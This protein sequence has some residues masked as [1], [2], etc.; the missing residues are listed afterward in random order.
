MTFVSGSVAW[1]LGHPYCHSIFVIGSRSQDRGI[2][3]TKTLTRV[4]RQ[5]SRRH[6][7]GFCL[8][9]ISTLTLFVANSAIAQVKLAGQSSAVSI[10]PAN[11]NPE[12]GK[13]T[14]FIALINTGDVV[15]MRRSRQPP[16]IQ[17]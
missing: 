2:A 5:A 7:V 15:S 12:F 11:T 10:A 8:V 3:M 6:F 14:H 17:P 4:E 9:L 1:H 13:P 16:L